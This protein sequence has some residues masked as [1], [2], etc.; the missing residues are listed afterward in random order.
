MRIARDTTGFKRLYSN[1]LYLIPDSRQV[2]RPRSPHTYYIQ[3]EFA[4]DADNFEGTASDRLA[5]IAKSYAALSPTEKAVCILL[6]PNDSPSFLCGTLS[7]G[8]IH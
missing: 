1:K 4:K 8:P 5:A 3:E 7:C 2:L 6:F